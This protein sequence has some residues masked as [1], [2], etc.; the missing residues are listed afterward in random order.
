MKTSIRAFAEK[1]NLALPRLRRLLAKYPE[2]V[3]VTHV[4]KSVNYYDS[5]GLDLW[6]MANRKRFSDTAVYKHLGNGETFYCMRNS[7]YAPTAKMGKRPGCCS[8][9][10]K[11]AIKMAKK[12][13]V[14]RGKVP[15]D[16]LAHKA[17]MEDMKM[18]RELAAINE[19]DWMNI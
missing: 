17:R 8:D 4:I 2:H 18:A 11:L 14:S 16:V 9:C 6:I 13:E 12:P 3:K 10:E 1:N 15:V 7:H 5:K 19:D